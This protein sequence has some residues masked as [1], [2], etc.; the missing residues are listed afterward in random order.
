M[1]IGSGSK[2]LPRVGAYSLTP[3]WFHHASPSNSCPGRRRFCTIR[4]YPSCGIAKPLVVGAPS[5]RLSDVGRSLRSAKPIVVQ[6][7]HLSIAWLKSG[8]SEGRRN[9][10]NRL[11][12]C[13]FRPSVPADVRPDR[14]GTASP[15]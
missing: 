12:R 3:L 1:P 9:T 13:P 8:D 11:A 2:Y 4:T 7:V 6:E 10:Y 5:H 15:M 14:T